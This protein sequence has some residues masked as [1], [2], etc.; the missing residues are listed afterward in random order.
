MSTPGRFL[1]VTWDGGGNTPSAF[2]LGARLV[3]HGHQVRLLGWETMASRAAAAGVGFA[4]YPS[5]A[6]LP[7][8]VALEDV[9]E[10]RVIPA[11]L[12][13]DTRDDI[14]AEAKRFTPDA[15]VVDS[16]VEAGLDAVEVLGLP[17]A[18]L[19]HVLYSAYT[20]EWGDPTTLAE[21]ARALGRAD[22]VLALVPPGFD[23]PC[24]LPANVTYVGPITAPHPPEPLDGRDRAVLAEPGDPWVL[25]SLS[26]TVQ[27]QAGALP[28]ILEAMA[29]LPVRVLLTL[30]GVMPAGAVDAPANVLVREFVPHELVL[31][32]MAAVVS[33]GGLSTVTAALAAGVP[34]LCIPQGRDQ[35]ANAQ[36]VADTGVGYVVDADA[37]APRIAGAL[38]QLLAD[39]GPRRRAAHFADAMNRLGGSAVAVKKVA[40]LHRG[41]AV[42]PPT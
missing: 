18:V 36:R 21:R 30:G 8:D 27:G 4:A 10:D 2:N 9:W 41:A 31:P 38:A 16:M 35:P 17:A 20:E 40:A 19:V 6:P 11:L 34:L 37:S 22:V 15:I 12:G 1:I 32:F 5:L 13:P 14:V 7:T 29:G 28:P 42:G 33:H 39:A 24:A 25:V 23:A 26:T 3:G